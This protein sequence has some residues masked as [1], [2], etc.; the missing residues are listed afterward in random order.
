MPA[1]VLFPHGCLSA[2]KA[3]L[4]IR[5]ALIVYSRLLISDRIPSPSFSETWRNKMTVVHASC[6][7]VRISWR[8]IAEI[9]MK[10]ILKRI[11]LFRAN[12]ESLD[13]SLIQVIFNYL[14][15]DL[16]L[17]PYHTGFS[18]TDERAVIMTMPKE[19]TTFSFHGVFN[20]RISYTILTCG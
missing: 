9:G 14:D 12:P 16:H 17:P 18:L 10:M 3:L 6:C 13:S 19:I 4:S 11:R 5:S 7:C 20:Y 1:R 15:A 2:D 8:I